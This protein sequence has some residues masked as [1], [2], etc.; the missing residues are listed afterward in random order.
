MKK[1]ML[2]CGLAIA[3]LGSAAA[4]T[5]NPAAYEELSLSGFTDWKSGYSGGEVRKFKIPVLYSSLRI[6]ESCLP[7]PAWKKK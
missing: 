7:I 6:L 3:V 5:F 4:Q 1:L 2:L